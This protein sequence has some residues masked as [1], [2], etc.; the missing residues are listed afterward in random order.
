MRKIRV[1]I[2]AGSQ[3]SVDVLMKD[4]DAQIKQLKE[5][6]SDIKNTHGARSFSLKALEK[7]K[8]A[9]TQINHSFA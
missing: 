9:L 2:V 6:L 1:K 7:A 4:V 3:S 5:Y 8:D